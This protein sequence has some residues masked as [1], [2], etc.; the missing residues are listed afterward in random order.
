MMEKEKLG[1]GMQIFCYP[2]LGLQSIWRI[3]GDFHTFATET[4]EVGK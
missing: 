2:L 1:K 3:F 4:V